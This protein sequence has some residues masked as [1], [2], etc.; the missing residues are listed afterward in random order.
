MSV[1]SL[2]HPTLRSV[3]W[4]STDSLQNQQC[5]WWQAL[6][7]AR[8]LPW[9]QHSGSV[10]FS[11]GQQLVLWKWWDFAG[12][13]RQ[14]FFFPLTLLLGLI[15]MVNDHGKNQ[16]EIECRLSTGGSQ[17]SPSPGRIAA[18]G[19]VGVSSGKW[20]KK[21]SSNQ[22]T[23]VEF[24]DFERVNFLFLALLRN[25][26]LLHWEWSEQSQRLSPHLYRSLNFT[27]NMHLVKAQQSNQDSSSCHKK[28]KS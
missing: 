8:A 6:F 15:H 18:Q 12:R 1:S 3:I 24:C 10:R 20:Q 5:W 2:V 17:P 26:P 19:T 23:S 13:S 7:L 11:L 21:K 27:S 22:M 28:K 25:L 14:C 9:L 16:V 4:W